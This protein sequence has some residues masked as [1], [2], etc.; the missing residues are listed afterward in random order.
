M[1]MGILGGAIVGVVVFGINPLQ[2]AQQM[3]LMIGVEDFAGGV[4]FAASW[5][6]VP[7][8]IFKPT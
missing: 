5:A 8:V 4:E 1:L 6:V 2:Y 7:G 3:K